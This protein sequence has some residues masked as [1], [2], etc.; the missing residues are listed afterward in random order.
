[1]KTTTTTTKTKRNRKNYCEL[2]VILDVET[3][4]KI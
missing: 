1:M 4:W 3:R 2:D